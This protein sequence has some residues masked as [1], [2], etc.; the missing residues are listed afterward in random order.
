MS[1]GFN[2]HKPGRFVSFISQ[3]GRVHIGSKMEENH[4]TRLGGI[5]IVY[6]AHEQFAESIRKSSTEIEEPCSRLQ[7]EKYFV[8]NRD[9]LPVY[10]EGDGMNLIREALDIMKI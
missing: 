1:R 9:L 5:I 3:K 2:A 4:F 6:V 10:R 8:V 7:L